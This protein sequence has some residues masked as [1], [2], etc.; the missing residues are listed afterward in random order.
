MSP[1]APAAKGVKILVVDDNPIIQRT[2]YFAL[3][4]RGYQV[5]ISG[6]IAEALNLVRKEMPN[7]ILLDINFPPDASL[8]GGGV[9]DG[10]WALD[11]MRRMEELKGVPI[12]IISGDD[13]TTASPRA[14]AAGA[15]GYL[16]KPIPK[17]VLTLTVAELLAEYPPA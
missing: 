6:T 14:R 15:A 11:W 12:V 5:S 8:G 1:A 13:P 7:L 2:I 3:R 4:D 17:D 16:H 9:R 10:F